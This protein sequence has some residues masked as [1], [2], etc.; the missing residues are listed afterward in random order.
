[1]KEID[2][3]ELKELQMQLLDYVDAFCQKNGIK[4]TISGGTLL[5]AVRHGGYIPWDDDIDIQMVRDEY[6][7]FNSIWHNNENQH[8]FELVSIE[9]GTCAGYAFGKVC[10]PKTFTIVEGMIRPGV[11][12]DVFPVDKVLGK[13]DFKVRHNIIKKMH[14]SAS[15]AFLLQQRKIKDIGIKRE[16]KAYLLSLGLPRTF[17]AKRINSLASIFNNTRSEYLY[18]MIAGMKCKS[19]IPMSVFCSYERISFENRTYMAVSDYDSYL[20]ATFGNYMKLPPKEKQIKE[21]DFI[22]YWKEV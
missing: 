9:N 3:T 2:S 14:Q 13:F 19:P 1:M 6:V 5:G 11:F 10:N 21:H 18:E 15:A 7:K 16:I 8:P 12:I 17:W 4:Y 20:S 22:A